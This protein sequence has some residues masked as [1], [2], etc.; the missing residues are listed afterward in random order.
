[1]KQIKERL[2]KKQL[3]LIDSK[4]LKYLSLNRHCTASTKK[5]FEELVEEDLCDVLALE[6]MVS[7]CSIKD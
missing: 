5:H 4:R 2:N 1:M 7:S 3:D 6:A